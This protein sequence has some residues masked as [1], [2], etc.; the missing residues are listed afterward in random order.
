MVLRVALRLLLP[1]G[2]QDELEH[3]AP[4]DVAVPLEI[5][6]VAAADHALA[7]QVGDIGEGPVVHGQ[8]REGGERSGIGW[9]GAG[10]QGGA[11]KH[12]CDVK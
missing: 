2:Q 6:V 8:V 12:L 7:D 5:A 11:E 3:L 1:Y 10:G 4:G 9:H